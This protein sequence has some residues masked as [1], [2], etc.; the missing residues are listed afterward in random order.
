MRPDKADANEQPQWICIEK[1]T[2][3]DLHL[4]TYPVRSA[5]TEPRPFVPLPLPT[6][7]TVP[8]SAK[9]RRFVAAP[10]PQPVEIHIASLSPLDRAL[11][12]AS[13]ARKEY[14]KNVEEKR[15]AVE[16]AEKAGVELDG[17]VRRLEQEKA[18]YEKKEPM[19]KRTKH[20]EKALLD[21]ASAVSSSTSHVQYLLSRLEA[22][23]SSAKTSKV[24]RKEADRKVKALR[25]EERRKKVR[26]YFPISPLPHCLPN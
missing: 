12:T 24:K 11:L 5:G 8:E 23:E 3:V 4:S 13:P 26:S 16:A 9:P 25:R 22:T 14:K 20:D 19:G 15:K 10:P 7:S 21:L 17:E 2:T 6:P 1:A 18:S